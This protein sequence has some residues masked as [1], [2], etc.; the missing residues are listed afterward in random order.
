MAIVTISNVSY[1]HGRKVAETL[2]EKLGYEFFSRDT[3]REDAS[4]QFNLPEIKIARVI[5][6]P[7]SLLDRIIGGK[8]KYVAYVRSVF[9]RRLQKDNIIY[10][11]FVGQFF[12]KDVPNI[13]KVL[14]TANLEDR[15]RT[16]M[17]REGISAG[18][19]QKHLEKI[20][21]ARS[22]WSRHLYG[23]DIWD[24]NLYDMV[25]RIDNMT[26][27]N[28]VDNLT[29]VIQLPCFQISSI[30]QQVN[31]KIIIFGNNCY[32]VTPGVVG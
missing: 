4:N 31:F 23:I 18:K 7:P 26:V 9:L 27:E 16:L 3:L 21:A 8:E 15:V 5:E 30:S 6:N 29:K 17:N 10:L 32:Q 1:C 13:L 24:P 20:D 22:K 25:L 28:V 12:V 19:A 14:V 11:G 2:A